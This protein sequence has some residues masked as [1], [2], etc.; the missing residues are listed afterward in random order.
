MHLCS[1]GAQCIIL[2]SLS[3]SL[4]PSRERWRQGGVCPWHQTSR[5]F[6]GRSCSEQPSPPWTAGGRPGEG[7]RGP[8][9]S[10][11]GALE[12][13]PY[14]VS[15]P[16]VPLGPRCSRGGG[17]ISSN[18]PSDT[19]SRACTGKRSWPTILCHREPVINHRWQVLPGPSAP[20]AAHRVRWE[21]WMRLSPRGPWLFLC[22]CVL[23]FPRLSSL[24]IFSPRSA[25]GQTGK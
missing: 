3:A 16:K 18:L 6:K 20:S 1:H 14:Q 11:R 21:R 23:P 10:E 7:H 15:C 13:R 17:Q 8:D 9:S 22:V 2:S 25:P 19:L 5:R 4:A 12:R 24:L